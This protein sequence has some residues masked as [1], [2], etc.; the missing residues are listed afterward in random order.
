MINIIILVG[1]VMCGILHYG[2]MFAYWQR[3]Y[4]L[5]AKDNYDS[6]RFFSLIGSILGPMTLVAGL[7]FISTASM[8]G[9]QGFKFK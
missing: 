8:K 9:Y 2:L 7:I 4:P 6:D 3:A 1:W 5:S